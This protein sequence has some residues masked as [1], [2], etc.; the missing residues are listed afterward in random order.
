MNGY[1]F[2]KTIYDGD[3]FIDFYFFCLLKFP[4]IAILL[5]L[6]LILILF[7]FYSRKMIKQFFAIY[8]IF[9]PKK[10]KQ[11][12]KFWDKNV[13]KIKDWYINQKNKNDIV[14]SASPYFLI[15]PICEILGIDKFI[16]TNMNI[17]TGAIKGKNCFGV[18]K[19]KQFL[20]RYNSQCLESFYSDSRSDFPMMRLAKNAFYVCGNKIKHLRRDE[21]I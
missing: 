11:V 17:M 21:I 4:Y 1:D 19:T 20:L 10:E 16:A 3:C 2:D 12:K 9:I 13:V 14:I 6:Q 15:I 8:L 5:P 18:E 7:S